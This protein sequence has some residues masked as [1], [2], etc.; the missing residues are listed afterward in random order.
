MEP[1]RKAL[2]SLVLVAMLAWTT[3]CLFFFLLLQTPSIAGAAEIAYGARLTII[4][5]WLAG[6]AIA[7]VV[8][9][10]SWRHT[11]DAT[12]MRLRQWSAAGASVIVVVL[13]IALYSLRL[14]GLLVFLW[15]P[16]V[17]GPLLLVGWASPPAVR[18]R[19]RRAL[20]L[21]LV[22]LGVV[23]ALWLVLP[24]GTLG[25]HLWTLLALLSL[26]AAAWW[27]WPLLRARTREV[28][29]G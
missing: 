22:G 18:L 16:M 24:P 6:L 14:S 8:V 3:Y 25:F 19:L 4:V 9:F 2:V 28:A 11:F 17:A 12:P 7:A 13:V 20:V 23:A 26:A 15:S 10:A 5:S 1:A 27:A 29:S 21:W